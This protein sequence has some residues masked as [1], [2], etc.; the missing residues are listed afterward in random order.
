MEADLNELLRVQ[1]IG[2]NAATLL[3]LV[4][5]LNVRYQCSAST[6]GTQICS[7][8]DAGAFLLPQLAYR[9]EECS[10]L[11]CMDNAG[12]VIDCHIMAEGT[13]SMVGLD[14][15]EIVETVLRD[16]AARV[17]LAHNHLTGI[18]LPSEAD[19]DATARLFRLLRMI[20]VELADHIIF[21]DGDYVSMR[22]S[23]HFAYF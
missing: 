8:D 3:R 15:R 12:H 19:V 6:R 14:A 10:V 16:R 21:S 13:T 9:N 22:E 7:I 1:G 18:A 4:T 2:E 5:E 23:G 11:L 20:G 17:I